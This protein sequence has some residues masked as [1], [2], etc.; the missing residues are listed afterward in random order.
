MGSP[1][2]SISFVKTR[3]FDLSVSLF[4]YFVEGSPSF[5][6]GSKQGATETNGCGSKQ[7][8]PLWGRRATILVHFSRDLDV[9]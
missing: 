4:P 6:S 8:V 1:P 3:P 7:M 2:A 9:H 5:I